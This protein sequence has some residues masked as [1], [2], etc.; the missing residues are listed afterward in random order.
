MDVGEEIKPIPEFEGYFASNYGN[1]FSKRKGILKKLKSNPGNKYGHLYV[2]IKNINS[3]FYTKSVHSLVLSA[4]N[5][6]CPQGMEA[7]HGPLGRL[8]NSITNLSWGT[9]KKNNEDKVRDGNSLRGLKNPNSKLLENDIILIRKLYLEEG[10][11]QR[12]I[13]KIF[14]VSQG[15]ISA[16]V[17][18]EF[19]SWVE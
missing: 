15:Q 11:R 9:R 1:I 4:F 13:A 2:R 17:R 16:I 18:K 6:N 12:Q 3:K 19:W 5:G 7:C 10:I 8:N 14:D